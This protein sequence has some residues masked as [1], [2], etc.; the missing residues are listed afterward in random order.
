VIAFGYFNPRYE[1]NKAV[2]YAVAFV[3]VYYI[4]ADYLSKHIYLNA[5]YTMPF[6][7]FLITY[8]VYSKR[9]KEFY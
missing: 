3:I 8:F 6:V 9:I 4:S 2:I 5:L 7:W 1:K